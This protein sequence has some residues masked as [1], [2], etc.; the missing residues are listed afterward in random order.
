MSNKKTLTHIPGDT[1]SHIFGN[2]FQLLKDQY[3]FSKD[4]YDTYGA[5]YKYKIFFE[6]CVSLCGPEA[7]EYL[8]MDRNKL[9]S[10]RQG[11]KN[12]LGPFFEGGLAL[13]DFEEHKMHRQCLQAAFKVDK[14]NQYIPIV[15]RAVDKN[16]SYLPSNGKLP[17]Y[18]FIKNLILETS[19][20]MLMGVD[21]AHDIKV[22]N[23]AFTYTLSACASIIR[24]NVPG[25]SFYRGIKARR[26]LSNYLHQLVK[27]KT[28]KPGDDMLSTLIKANLSDGTRLSEEEIVNHMIFMMMA[29]HDTTTIAVSSLLYTL[30]KYPLWQDRLHTQLFDLDF[31][32]CEI[33]ME[34]LDRLTL[35]DLVLNES[36][37]LFPPAQGIR[38]KTI[39]PFDYSGYHIPGG[40]TVSINI[41][42]SHM[43]PEYWSDPHKFDPERF[44]E[45][46][47]EHKQ[48]RFLYLPFG[49]GAHKCIGMKLA[50]FE[51][52]VI[53]A[54]L[55][56][57][58]QFKLVD[59]YKMKIHL[60]PF[61][62]PADN[63]PLE[64]KAR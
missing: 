63:L 62:I 55:L 6:E 20:T 29:A 1:G 36:L 33:T 22:V 2:T 47:A 23:T 24:M 51:I 60:K 52:K 16:M 64:I 43:L 11:W 37:R 3:R 10:N 42:L 61:P 7:N 17:F 58:Y 53:V 15:S 50:Q 34:V 59:N 31:Q 57:K 49:G 27:N 40:T 56:L 12:M 54:K 38:R 41:S 18:P 28:L 45:S 14:I 26:Y 5:V 44:N 35:F 4:R 46:R 39:M 9:F 13:R 25:T 8:L 21:I 19:A 48:H 32:D 30:A